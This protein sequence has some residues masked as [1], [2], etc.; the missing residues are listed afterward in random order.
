VTPRNYA[1]DNRVT[2]DALQQLGASARGVAVVNQ[3]VTDAELK[4]LNDGGIRGTRFTLGDPA[5]AVVRWDVVEPLA[6]RA[7]DIGWHLQFNIDGELIVANADLLRR[8]PTQLARIGLPVCSI[9]IIGQFAISRSMIVL[10]AVPLR[11]GR[12]TA[13]RRGRRPA[14]HPW[15]CAG[16]RPAS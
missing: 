9:L 3:T 12:G 7:A 11:R 16:S 13:R 10:I 6:K 15:T 4:S 8:L 14:T 1:T 2:L 5:T